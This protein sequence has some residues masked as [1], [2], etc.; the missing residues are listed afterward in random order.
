MFFKAYYESPHHLLILLAAFLIFRPSVGVPVA[1]KVLTPDPCVEKLKLVLTPR[2]A[3][4]L[5]ALKLNPTG[6]AGWEDSAGLAPNW[7]TALDCAGA[8]GWLPNTPPNAGAACPVF[9]LL[10]PNAGG[11]DPNA[12]IV[13]RVFPLKA[14]VAPDPVPNAGVLLEPN[15]ACVLGIPGRA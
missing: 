4:L 15:A 14:P 6:C 5:L 9:E 3:G 1:L 10:E 8:A 12:C 13:D 11:V 7:N 2:P